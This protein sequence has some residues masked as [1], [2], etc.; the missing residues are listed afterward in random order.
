MT[1]I[2]RRRFI[3]SSA[4]AGLARILPAGE[5]AT[6]AERSSNGRVSLKAGGDARTGYRIKWWLRRSCENRFACIRQ[7]SMTCF[8]R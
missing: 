1:G 2:S 7:I 6:A 8:T 4:A 3:V 5:F